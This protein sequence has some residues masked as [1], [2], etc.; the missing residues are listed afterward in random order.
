[1]LNLRARFNN[2]AWRDCSTSLGR[3]V[4]TKYYSNPIQSN[5]P[6][7]KKALALGMLVF[8]LLGLGFGSVFFPRTSTQTLTSTTTL[9][10]SP[11]AATTQTVTSTTVSTTTV[12]G[13]ATSYGEV[14]EEIIVG[15]VV[16]NS[17]C[18]DM[19]A[20]TTQTLFL[21]PESL[22]QPGNLTP[23]LTTTVTF[24]NMNTTTTYAS[25]TFT[26]GETCV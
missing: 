24:S 5:L 21:L 20:T 18:L 15:V 7:D 22:S 1:M 26:S 13:S 6:L 2:N 12:I 10:G 9:T 4:R 11:A 16:T 14:T 17:V 23:A 3:I 8:L 19:F 25:V